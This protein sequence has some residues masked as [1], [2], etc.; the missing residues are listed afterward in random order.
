MKKIKISFDPIKK[1]LQMN[2]I[3]LTAFFF[4]VFIFACNNDKIIQDN[5]P[6]DPGDAGKVSLQGIDS[7][8]D[9]LRDDVQRYIYLNFDREDEIKVLT[10]LAENIQ[11]MIFNAQDKGIVISA[12]QKMSLHMEC[13]HYLNPTNAATVVKN[14]EALIANTEARFAE[15]MKA[16]EK[17]SGEIFLSSGIDN[18]KDSCF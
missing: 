12:A 17:L 7:D 5:L 8:N 3:L 10:K 1:S 15:Y 2:H 14:I 18:F 4:I 11:N 16:N 6:P 13:L 9:G